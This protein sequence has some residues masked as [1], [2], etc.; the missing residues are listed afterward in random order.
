MP[1]TPATTRTGRAV[2]I[3][4]EGESFYRR[5]NGPALVLSA[6]G[7][8]G[9]S[10]RIAPPRQGK[11]KSGGDPR[12]CSMLPSSSIGA[13]LH[14]SLGSLV[15]LRGLIMRFPESLGVI[16]CPCVLRGG[17]PV[18]AVSH[19]GG[20][21]QMYCSWQGH[22]FSDHETL[23]KEFRLV[24]VEHLVAEDPT[25]LELGDLPDDMGAEREAIGMPWVRFEDKDD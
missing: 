4:P 22:D 8:N 12:R 19:A 14:G 11:A 5:G 9:R 16:A 23:R 17:K 7:A 25:L 20:D 6:A 10:D 3:S 24:H 21:W 18:L 2:L 13:E 15:S 1:A